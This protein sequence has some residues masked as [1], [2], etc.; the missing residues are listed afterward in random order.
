M[1]YKIRESLQDKKIPYVVVV[2]DKEIEEGSVAIRKRGKGPIGTLKIDEFV[3]GLL[4]EIKSR[5]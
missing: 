3:S 4:E 5:A 1:K 2:G